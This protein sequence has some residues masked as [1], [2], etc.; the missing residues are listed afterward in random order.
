[1]EIEE[2]GSLETTKREKIKAEGE[3]VE[4]VKTESKK[5]LVKIKGPNFEVQ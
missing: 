1:M 3:L 4:V 5:K 2:E